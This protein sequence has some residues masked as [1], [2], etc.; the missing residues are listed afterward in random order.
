MTQS[1]LQLQPGEEIVLDMVLS[2]FWTWPRYLYTLG[3]WAFWRA[4][5]RF[6][7]TN[8]RVIVTAGIVTSRQR[9]VPLARVQDVTLQR[10]ILSGG[11]LILS[12]A[13]GPTGVERIG[14][15]SRAKASQF[16]LALGARIHIGSDGVS[17]AAHPSPPALSIAS[18]L[19]RLATLRDRGVL[20]DEEFDAQKVRLLSD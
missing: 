16:T 12:S 11:H 18:E 14:P 1:R 7:L 15:L 9:T 3:F 2:P 10:S 5:H 8:Q 19:E 20:T 6:V 17:G 4:R 13:G